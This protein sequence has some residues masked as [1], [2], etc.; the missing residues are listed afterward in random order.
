MDGRSPPM[1]S[2]SSCTCMSLNWAVSMVVS[3]LRFLAWVL[4]RAV[5]QCA[6]SALRISCHSLELNIH[7]FAAQDLHFTW[8]RV[9]KFSH[10]TS[11]CNHH[12][13]VS[14]SFTKFECQFRGPS[15]GGLR[16][17]KFAFAQNHAMGPWHVP[18]M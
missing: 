4:A 9:L 14:F 17:L 18:G 2:M 5:W 8:F 1:A 10:I 15:N 7:G 16:N 12:V 11:G 6:V 3:D 13:T